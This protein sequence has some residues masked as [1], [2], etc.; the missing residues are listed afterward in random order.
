MT[1]WSE[2]EASA[3][4]LATKGRELFERYRVMLLGT[5]KRDG[6]ARVTPVEPAFLFGELAIGM[7]RNSMKALDLMRDP[8]ITVH[9]AVCSASGDDG[10]FI[11]YGRA[12]ELSDDADW[13][14][15]LDR[16]FDEIGW[17]PPGSY[18]QFV[19][20]IDR[21]WFVRDREGSRWP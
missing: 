8:R 11:L 15:S 12:V 20:D 5:R 21:A 10:E 19:I 2:F 4:D 14:A 1:S 7:P 3:P 17:H 16:H 6:W 13:M 18:F 9:S